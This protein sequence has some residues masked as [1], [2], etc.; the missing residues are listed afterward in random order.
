MRTIF[1][2]SFF[3]ETVRSLIDKKRNN[4][5]FLLAEGAVFL[6]GLYLVYQGFFV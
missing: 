3:P 2:V 5:W 4:Y 1:G 6:M